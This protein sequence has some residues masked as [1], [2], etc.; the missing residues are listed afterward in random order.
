[1]SPSAFDQQHLSTGDGHSLYLAQFGKPNAPAAV[2]LHGGP[3]SGT[4]P[5]VL[6]W[7]DLDHQCVVLFDQRGAGQ[8]TPHGELQHNDSHQL[9]ADIELIRTHLGIDDWMVVGGSWG[10]TLALLY[11]GAHTPRVNSLIVRG[12]FFT[13]PREM[14]WC[15]QSLCAMVPQAWADLTQGWSDNEQ[16]NVLATLSHKLLHESQQSAEDAA[17]R[18]SRYED[19]VMQAMAGKLSSKP[20]ESDSSRVPTRTLAK[21]KLQAHYLSNGCFTSETE[22]LAIAKTLSS[23]PTVLIHGTHDLICPPENA[24]R[25]AKEMPHAQL[26]LIERGG[27]TPSDQAIANALK[28][29]ISELCQKP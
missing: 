8:S 1:M 23:I 22:L 16:R 10:A 7:F 28:Q 9:V 21:Y 20:R 29:A 13:S 6:D 15:F 3:G 19:A 4:Q 5:S 2:V 24:L 26:R 27:H 17:A 25:L 12:S 14:I 11:A 18:W